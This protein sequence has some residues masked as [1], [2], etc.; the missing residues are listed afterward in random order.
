M[1]L[2]SIVDAGASYSTTETG[3]ACTRYATVGAASY[4]TMGA[5][6]ACALCTPYSVLERRTQSRE[7][8]PHARQGRTPPFPVS[9]KETWRKGTVSTRLLASRVL[10]E[11]SRIH[12]KEIQLM[13]C[14]LSGHTETCIRTNKILAS[15]C[16]QGNCRSGKSVVITQYLLEA[17]S[18][19][20]RHAHDKN[21]SISCK[22]SSAEITTPCSNSL[23][24]LCLGTRT[25][26]I[27]SRHR[28]VG[29]IRRSFQPFDPF[30]QGAHCAGHPAR[31]SILPIRH[32]NN[33]LKTSSTPSK[34]ARDKLNTIHHKRTRNHLKA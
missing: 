33:R 1:C 26:G 27:V 17:I 34:P 8:V 12:V 18:M 10:T 14:I 4:S 20:W 22:S 6:A 21:F 11:H 13:N 31:C 24:G 29:A 32:Q 28:G 25:F 9:A 16:S 15:H 19:H 3:V 23:A 30:L 7:E 5:G 2:H